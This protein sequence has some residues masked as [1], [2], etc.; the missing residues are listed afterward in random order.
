MADH[1][2]KTNEFRFEDFQTV[3]VSIRMRS[4]IYGRCLFKTETVASHGCHSVKRQQRNRIEI[5]LDPSRPWNRR[6]AQASPVAGEARFRFPQ[7]TSCHICG[8][9]FLARMPVALPNAPNQ[10]AILAWQDFPKRGTRP[11]DHPP[12]ETGWL[13]GASALATLPEGFRFCRA[14]DKI[15]IEHWKT[16]TQDCST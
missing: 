8:R 1:P 6:L 2:A 15:W 10:L 13:A 3:D 7:A 5:G 14:Q 16:M 12:A 11:R 4:R 9:L